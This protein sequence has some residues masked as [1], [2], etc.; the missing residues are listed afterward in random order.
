VLIVNLANPF[1]GEGYRQN[2]VRFFN[3]VMRP[4]P[5]HRPSTSGTWYSSASGLVKQAP[6]MEFAWRA[7]VK[8]ANMF[9]GYTKG[10]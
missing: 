7:S 5:L 10:H 2:W 9:A 8:P 4:V 6:W 3:F 1:E